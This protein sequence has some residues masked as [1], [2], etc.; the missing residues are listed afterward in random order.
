M[1]EFMAKTFNSNCLN[2]KE[3]LHALE[4]LSI[5]DSD[6]EGWDTMKREY[7]NAVDQCDD[8]LEA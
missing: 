6:D 5:L 2:I 1:Y 4:H 7:K 8:E 3:T